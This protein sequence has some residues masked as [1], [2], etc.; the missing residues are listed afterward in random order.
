MTATTILDSAGSDTGWIIPSGYTAPKWF[1]RS[2]IAK[3]ATAAAQVRL[4]WP[5]WAQAEKDG[6]K[7]LGPILAFYNAPPRDVRRI[8]GGHAWH[9]IRTATLMQNTAR[10][11]LMHSAGW[12]V[13]QALEWPK[14]ATHVAHRVAQGNLS[15]DALLFACR[16]ADSL[17]SFKRLRILFVDCL[18]MR[19]DVSPDWGL[20]RVRR[21]H[22]EAAAKSVLGIASPTPWAA[23]WSMKHAGYRFTL[24]TSDLDLAAEGQI[25]HHCVASYATACRAGLEF[26]FRV[27]GK[28]RATLSFEHASRGFQVQASY[29][30]EVRAETLDACEAC[31]AAFR[32]DRRL[33]PSNE[34]ISRSER[35]RC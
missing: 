34:K 27:E 20:K 7:H 24:L 9:A 22:D 26:V 1:L 30:R 25:Q 33:K 35:S 13:G 29:N 8:V 12:S 6:L 11:I 18:R 28:E 19:V 21:A 5:H 3:S 16:H 32:R 17:E 10:F 31:I 15:R 2:S 14:F 23:P 4:S